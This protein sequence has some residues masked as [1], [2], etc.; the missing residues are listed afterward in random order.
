MKKYVTLYVLCS[1]VECYFL[2]LKT[3]VSPLAALVRK[4]LFS[5]I[6]NNIHIFA[7]SCNILYLFQVKECLYIIIAF[8]CFF[9]FEKKNENLSAALTNVAILKHKIMT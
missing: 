4:I 2:V 1:L 7:P 6:E 8:T 5:Q 3:I 9:F